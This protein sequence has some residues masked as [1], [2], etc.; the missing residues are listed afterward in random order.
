MQPA[1]A[2]DDVPYIYYY[3][4]VL[5]GIVVER[6]DGTDSRVLGRGLVEED[7]LFTRG[8]GWSSDGMWF[9]WHVETP[10]GFYPDIGKGYAVHIDGQQPL[11]LLE[12]FSCVHSSG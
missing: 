3:S 10:G 6:A 8:P 11:D 4:N 7:V 1:F 12:D 2:Q 5:K 9:A